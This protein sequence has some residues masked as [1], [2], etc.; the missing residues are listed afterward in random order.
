MLQVTYCLVKQWHQWFPKKIFLLTPKIK[1]GYYLRWLKSSHQQILMQQNKRKRGS[2]DFKHWFV[3]G[4]IKW[5]SNSSCGWKVDLLQNE[6]KIY[7]DRSLEGWKRILFKIFSPTNALSSTVA[8]NIL[9]LQAVSCCDTCEGSNVY[10]RK[11]DIS[12]NSCEESIS[13]RIC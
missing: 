2:L 5:D 7:F 9:F 1:V 12:Q 3:F 11:N 10:G 13:F 6:Q 4:S 8:E